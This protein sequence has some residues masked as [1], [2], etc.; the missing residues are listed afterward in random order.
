LIRPETAIVSIIYANNEIGTINELS[1]FSQICRSRGVPFHSDAVQA[2]SQLSINVDRLG[3]DLMSIGAHKFYGPK[4]VG[5]LY[6]RSGTELHP[7]LTGGS[8]ENARRAGTHNVPLIVGMAEALQITVNERDRHNQAYQIHR[9]R[10]LHEIP[11]LIPDVK[12]SGHS[13]QRLPNHTSFVFRGVDGNE[14]LIGLDIAGFACSSGSA[15]KTGNP[16]PSDVLKAL[17][18]DDDWALGSLRV[19]VGRQTTS[20]EIDRFLQILPD[21]I[22]ELRQ[23]NV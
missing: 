22:E 21:L 3:V 18:L 2:A 11:H 1:Q 14:L 12:I 19:T 6:V 9:D 7:I 15:C 13:E 10:L 5:A 23:T 4:G 17:G 16:E 20:M 8:Q